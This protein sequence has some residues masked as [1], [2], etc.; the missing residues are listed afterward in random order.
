MSAT[1]VAT[2]HPGDEQ[3]NTLVI[4]DIEVIIP[5]EEDLDDDP[6]TPDQ[7]RLRNQ[8]GLYQA[9]LT[10]GGPGVEPDGD[11]PLNRYHF[12][13]VVPGYYTIEVKVGKNWHAVARD[14]HIT[15]DDA[16]FGDVS[17]VGT[18]DGS[19]MGT[20]D[21]LPSAE[22]DDTKSPDFGIC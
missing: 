6:K 1:L 12:P 11:N 15:R 3:H 5:L 14:I 21:D 18:A 16:T 22:L 20:P 10:E 19:V 4:G 2:T 13:A 17:L 7:V 8:A 9:T